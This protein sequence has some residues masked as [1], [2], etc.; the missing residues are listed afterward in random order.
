[1][2]PQGY[3]ITNAAAVGTHMKPKE[4]MKTMALAGSGIMNSQVP[5][6][7]GFSGG[8]TPPVTGAAN[9][10]EQIKPADLNG[11]IGTGT[12]G[13]RVVTNIGVSPQKIDQYNSQ[14]K[15]GSE[16]KKSAQHILNR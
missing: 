11:A 1:M 4:E 3:G 15:R 8:P 9:N 13:N 6:S 12:T 14:N 2:K 16:F 10:Y 7:K 5:G